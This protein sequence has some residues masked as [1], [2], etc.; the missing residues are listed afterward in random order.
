MNDAGHK[1]SAICIA[2][3][4]LVEANSHGQG[5]GR[6]RVILSF[7][8]TILAEEVG[9][10]EDRC[11]YKLNDMVKLL[12]RRRHGVAK[13]GRKEVCL[14]SR[15]R[16]R[17]REICTPKVDGHLEDWKRRHG[18]SDTLS[19]AAPIEEKAKL[20]CMRVEGLKQALDH[21]ERRLFH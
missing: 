14:V 17:A 1:C 16:V 18:G 8:D 3:A 21:I 10:D 2:R 5:D 6:P 9:A 19:E 12:S 11:L 20:L 7:H 13:R 15:Q 4:Y